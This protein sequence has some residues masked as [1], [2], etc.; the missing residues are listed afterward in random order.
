MNIV[1]EILFW[2]G[3]G[4]I[5]GSFVVPDPLTGIWMSA[6]GAVVALG[7]LLG[8]RFLRKRRQAAFDRGF[9]DLQ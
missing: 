2:L 4:A 8:Q 1:L 3:F 9:K 6:I 7:A 5:M